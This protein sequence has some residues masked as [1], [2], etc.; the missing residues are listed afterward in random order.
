MY[1]AQSRRGDELEQLQVIAGLDPGRPERQVAVALAHLR[2]SADPLVPASRRTGHADLAVLTLSSALERTPD[3]PLVYAALG[4]VW[5]DI[6]RTRN[7][8]AALNKAIEAL[9]H[10]GSTNDATSESLMLYG[11]ALLQ[12]GQIELAERTLEQATERYPVEPPAFVLYAR[13]ADQQHHWEAARQAWLQYGALVGDDR[14]FLPRA[15]HIAELS[16][17][18]N[19]TATAIEWLARANAASADARLVELL[20][21]AQLKGG[22]RPAAAATVARGLDK[23]PTDAALVALSRRLR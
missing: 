20:A 16:L 9:E 11:Q 8:P 18:V 3:H 21:E 10:V 5:L 19:D 14:D 17:H 13:A 6:A 15:E 2:W 7:D 22:D 23:Y 1:A 4:R 12:A